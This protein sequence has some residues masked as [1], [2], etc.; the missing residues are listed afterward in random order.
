MDSHSSPFPSAIAPAAGWSSPIT[1]SLLIIGIF[2]VGSFIGWEY[3]LIHYSSFPPL[4]PLDIWLRDHGRFAAMQAVGFMEWAC[5]TALRMYIMLYYQNYLGLGPLYTIYRFLP[6]PVAGL[7]G[8][9][10]VAL[11][12]GRIKGAYLLSMG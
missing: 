10:A 7:V 5:Y 12:V 11:I 9:I 1:I 3:Y 4:I 6:N 8:N 2:L